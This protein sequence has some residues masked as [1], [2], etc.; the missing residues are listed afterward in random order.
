MSAGPFECISQFGVR[1]CSQGNTHCKPGSSSHSS[2]DRP[3][4]LQSL[5]LLPSHA[6]LA[7][8]LKSLLARGPRIASSYTIHIH[9]TKGGGVLFFGAN[10]TGRQAKTLSRMAARKTTADKDHEPADANEQGGDQ[11]HSKFACFGSLTLP[12]Y[13]TPPSMP[14][15]PSRAVNNNRQ[16][17]PANRSQRTRGDSNPRCPGN[18]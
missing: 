4:R 12:S 7:A 3:C 5:P 15:Y 2:L 13:S 16:R 8:Y 10:E 9:R 1:H 14:L 18:I 17:S 11:S 6:H